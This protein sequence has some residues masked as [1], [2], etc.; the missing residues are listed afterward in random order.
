[1]CCSLL[2]TRGATTIMSP[3]TLDHTR[4]DSATQLEKIIDLH[5]SSQCQED[6]LRIAV[7]GRV[8]LESSVPKVLKENQVIYTYD[9]DWEAV[10]LKMLSQ[11]HELFNKYLSNKFLDKCVNNGLISRVEKSDI[12][13]SQSPVRLPGT[14]SKTS[15]YKREAWNKFP[16]GLFEVLDKRLKKFFPKI[17]VEVGV[18]QPYEDLLLDM[19]QWLQKSQSINT[20]ILVNITESN[21]LNPKTLNGPTRDRIRTLIKEFGTG[22][23]RDVHGHEFDTPDDDHSDDGNTTISFPGYYDEIEERVHAEDWV[24]YLIMTIEIWT[25][26]GDSLVLRKRVV[27]RRPLVIFAQGY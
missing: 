8:F 24:G 3:V 11:I 27:V 12:Y 21:K 7:P 25:K 13:Y 2:N 16:D 9:P 5:L 22:E 1:M 20:V 10:H 19:E 17:A 15:I 18:T 23:C 14:I 6:D 26:A 4:I